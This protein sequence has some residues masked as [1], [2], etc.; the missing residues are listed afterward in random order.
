[1]SGT[2]REIRWHPVTDGT[3]HVQGSSL[4]SLRTLHEKF[5]MHCKTPIPG[6]P[7]IGPTRTPHPDLSNVASMR[8]VE[9][10]KP[11]QRHI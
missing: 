5:S 8:S 4:A 6:E 9:G 11:A 2:A 1:M 10:P 3:T 7:D